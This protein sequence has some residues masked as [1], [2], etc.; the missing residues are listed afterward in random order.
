[1]ERRRFIGAAAAAAS[2]PYVADS[3]KG[4]TQDTPDGDIMLTELGISS[5]ESPARSVDMAFV[6]LRDL[7]DSEATIGVT[8]VAY[9]DEPGEVTLRVGLSSGEVSTHHSADEARELARD[10]MNAADHAE[11]EVVTDGD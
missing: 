3:G 6:E 8:G 9:D 4:A 7:V 10:L 5:K 11:R 2:I 1:M